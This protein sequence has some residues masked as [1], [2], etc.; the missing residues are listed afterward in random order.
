MNKK[1]I[2][3]EDPVEKSIPFLKSPGVVERKRGY[4]DH[5]KNPHFA[6]KPWGK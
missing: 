5:I 1:L 4:L 2:F 6:H 3:I